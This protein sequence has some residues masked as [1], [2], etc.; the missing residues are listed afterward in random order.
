MGKHGAG[1]LHRPEDDVLGTFFD[2]RASRI[3]EVLR[4]LR[5]LLEDAYRDGRINEV[6]VIYPQMESITRFLPAAERIL[7]MPQKV[8]EEKPEL[9]L[10]EPDLPAVLNR[11]IPAFFDSKL[12]LV[13]FNALLA[14]QMARMSAMRQA[15]KN[16]KDMIDAL[17]LQRNKAR[18][19]AI[20]KEIIEVV[21][22]SRA[23]KVK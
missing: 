17:T 21:S 23:L 4:E 13:F 18:Q 9:P 19:A 1:Q 6:V 15:T 8:T 11:L 2:L 7:P 10:I 5:R 14:E 22:G 12:R 3:E 20:T 16:A